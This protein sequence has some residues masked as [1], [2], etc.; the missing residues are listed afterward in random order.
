VQRLC[1]PNVKDC[2]FFAGFLSGQ[3]RAPYFLQLAGMV[4]FIYFCALRNPMLF[5]GVSIS[6]SGSPPE[7]VLT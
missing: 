4:A 7:N 1:A 2:F 6:M 3:R 5:F